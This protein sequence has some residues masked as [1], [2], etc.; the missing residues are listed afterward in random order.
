[1]LRSPLS[2]ALRNV[3]L[4]AGAIVA[5][6]GLISIASAHDLF[7][8]TPARNPFNVG[9]SEGGGRATGI[10]GWIMAQQIAFERMLSG[11]VRAI[12]T[13][14]SALWTLLGISF[15]YGVFHA[16]G[17]GH[18]KAVV[19][20]YMLANERALRRGIAISFFAAV[21]QGLVAI[22]I[23][24]V[25]ALILNATSQQMRQTANFVELASYAGIA[26]LGLWLVWRKGAALLAV[27]GAKREATPAEA[28]HHDHAH[29]HHTHHH[30]HGHDHHDH[31]AHTHNHAHDIALHPAP[32]GHPEHVHDEHCGHFHAPDPKTLGD[33]F[34]WGTA[35]LTVVAAGSRP[36]SGAILVLVFALAQGIFTAGIAAAFA[37]SIGTA[38]TTGALA[39]IAV[40]AKNLALRYAN[41]DSS[42]S[43]TLMRLFEFGAACLVLLMGV[44]MFFG[45]TL[46]A[47]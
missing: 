23:V 29:D 42:R 44:A 4:L 39:A 8:Q 40:L 12:K 13:D 17:P 41:P 7:A 6:V 32:H 24:G 38:L 30:D 34:S 28:A 27:L 10:M 19:A 36:C 16:A 1:M 33:N 43:I 22:A 25:L 3:L 46:G 11:T 20:S 47:A 37:M 5:V 2:T 31:T 15:A 21:L 9:I 26:V 45:A 35:L 14:G 18:G